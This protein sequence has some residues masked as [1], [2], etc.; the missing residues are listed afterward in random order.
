MDNQPPPAPSPILVADTPEAFDMLRGVLASQGPLVR[1]GTLEEAKKLVH[2]D[3][4]LVICGCHFDEGRMYELLRWMRTQ[5]ALVATPFLSIR[6]LEGALD[7]A[8]YESVKIATRVLGGDGFVDLYRWQ[9]KYGPDKAA[10]RLAEGV[11]QLADGTPGWA[12]SE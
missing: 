1:A 8:M 3:T 9:R 11:R 6:V 5:P 7:D 12:G 4:R 2:G 10:A